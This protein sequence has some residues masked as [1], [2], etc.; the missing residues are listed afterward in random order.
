VAGA[1]AAEAVGLG[2]AEVAGGGRDSD[3]LPLAGD[4]FNDLPAAIKTRLF[5]TFDI[6]VAWNKPTPADPL[7]GPGPAWPWDRRDQAGTGGQDG[8]REVRATGEMTRAS[9]KAGWLACPLIDTAQVT[10]G[11]PGS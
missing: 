9:V 11:Q 3:Q 7:S 5:Q 2:V 4:I 8:P 1:G 6:E 10:G